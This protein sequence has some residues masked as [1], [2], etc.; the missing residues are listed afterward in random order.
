MGARADVRRAGG[1]GGAGE[2]LSTPTEG[3]LCVTAAW[4]VEVPGA[5]NDGI[6]PKRKARQTSGFT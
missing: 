2:L 5:V 1:K 4:G 6:R 3:H